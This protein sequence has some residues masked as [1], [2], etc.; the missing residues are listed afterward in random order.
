MNAYRVFMGNPEG[1]KPLART[2][3]RCEDNIKMHF[4]EIGWGC[5]GTNGGLL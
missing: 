3:H 2:I 1:N 4:R 5:M